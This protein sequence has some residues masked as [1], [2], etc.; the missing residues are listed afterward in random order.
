MIETNRKPRLLT[1]AAVLL[2]SVALVIINIFL[3]FQLESSRQIEQ[4]TAASR[5]QWV[6][7]SKQLENRK[8]E[9]QSIRQQVRQSSRRIEDLI[10]SFKIDS[11]KD[12][13]LAAVK[14]STHH[15]VLL[16]KQNND[17][18]NPEYWIRVPES[19]HTMVVEITKMSGANTDKSNEERQAADGNI[20][21]LEIPLDPGEV[22]RLGYR[23]EQLGCTVSVRLTT[24]SCS[25]TIHPTTPAGQ[26]PLQVRID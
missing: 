19:G 25:R 9:L 14:K 5:D 20:E 21:T 17:M 10:Q 12:A 3:S 2:I 7:M 6:K 8:V 15:H 26:H 16:L 11:A 22:Y 23:V 24:R 4:S 1:I 13:A 18:N